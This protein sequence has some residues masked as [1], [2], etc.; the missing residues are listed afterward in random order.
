MIEGRGSLLAMNAKPFECGKLQLVLEVRYRVVLEFRDEDGRMQEPAEEWIY[1]G[2]D[3]LPY[4]EGLT[5]FV[6]WADGGDGVIRM[7][8]HRYAQGQ[9][10]DVFER[11]VTRVS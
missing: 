10:L 11:Y 1:R 3:F 8:W 2:Y 7:Q 4:D 5:L 9:V 6:T